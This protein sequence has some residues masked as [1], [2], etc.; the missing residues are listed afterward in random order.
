MRALVHVGPANPRE[1]QEVI[2]TEEHLRPLADATSADV[3]RIAAAGGVSV[4]RSVAV[5]ARAPAKG[6]GWI[7]LRRSE[8]TSLESID[9]LPLLGGLLG[10]LLLAGGFVALWFR[11]GR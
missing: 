6:R 7:G 3:V 8:A 5:S 1:Y 10:L 2:S 9:R 4:P 11:E